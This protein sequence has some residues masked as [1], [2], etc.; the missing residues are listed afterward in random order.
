MLDVPACRITHRMRIDDAWHGALDTARELAC[1]WALPDSI[2]EKQIN[3]HL[4]LLDEAMSG[5]ERR[6][7]IGIALGKAE[8]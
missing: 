1:Q 3:D 8:A 2:I 4:D 7:I 6:I 5:L